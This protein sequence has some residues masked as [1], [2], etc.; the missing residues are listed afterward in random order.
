MV[1]VGELCSDTV[2][3]K[4]SLPKTQHCF[5]MLNSP[6]NYGIVTFLVNVAVSFSSGVPPYIV[7]SFDF[8]LEIYY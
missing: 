1:P 3:K 5:G 6:S 4:I 7:F 2:E 8:S